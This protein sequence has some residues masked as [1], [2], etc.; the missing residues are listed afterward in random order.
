MAGLP[1]ALK[2]DG[3]WSPSMVCGRPAYPPSLVSVPL[4]AIRQAATLPEPGS[5]RY[6]KRPSGLVRRSSGVLPWTLPGGSVMPATD[7]RSVSFRFG[8]MLQLEIVPEL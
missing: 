6:R 1:S 7:S 5:T 8:A 4:E 3:A 2:S